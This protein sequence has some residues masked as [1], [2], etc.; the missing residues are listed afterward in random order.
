MTMPT[1][2]FEKR[3]ELVLVNVKTVREIAEITKKDGEFAKQWE[4]FMLIANDCIKASVPKLRHWKVGRDSKGQFLYY[5]GD[6]WKV[7]KDDLIAVAMDYDDLIEPGETNDP[8]VGLYVPEK[9]KQAEL[10]RD[11]L[12]N[13]IDKEQSDIWGAPETQWPIWSYVKIEDFI[14]GSS[15]DHKS[16]LKDAAGKIALIVEMRPLIDQLLKKMRK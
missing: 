13:V 5:P 4:K 15:F 3:T 1:F 7:L 2:K 8:W 9:W 11:R 16:F 14:K 10:F 12:Q 6:H